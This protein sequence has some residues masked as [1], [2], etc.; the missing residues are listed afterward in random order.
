MDITKVIAL[1][2]QIKAL[3]AELET[4]TEKE[5]APIV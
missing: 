2:A 1:I 4:E 5:Q 3:I